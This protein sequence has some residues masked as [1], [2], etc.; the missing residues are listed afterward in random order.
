MLI[1]NEAF[2][3]KDLLQGDILRVTEDLAAVLNEFHPYYHQNPENKYLVVLTQEC[4]L[5]RRG[6]SPCKSPYILIGVVRYFSVLLERKIEGIVS[7]RSPTPYPILS[8][9]ENSGLDQFL[10]R[11]FN[12]NETD[13][14]FFPKSPSQGFPENCCAFLR[15]AVPIK[16]EHYDKCVDAKILEINDAH[17]AKLG[18]KIGEIYSRVGTEDLTS[19]ELRTLKKEAINDELFTLPQ[20]GYKIFE[21]KLNEWY[22]NNPG[23]TID[24]TALNLI[25]DEVP[26]KRDQVI[27]YLNENIIGFPTLKGFIPDDGDREA[28]ANK[29]VAKIL[30]DG[31]FTALFK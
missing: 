7:H 14:Y 23:S 17:R 25:L 2:S 29:L 15:L 30:T 21:S 4:D 8:E 12:N 24:E 31:R 9:K 6:S 11:I 22:K 20:F 13:Y 1:Y 18:Y 28:F 26:E 16:A 19:T 5:A 10:S 27:K 3:S